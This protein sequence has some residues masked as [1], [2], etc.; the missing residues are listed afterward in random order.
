M[1]RILTVIASLLYTASCATMFNRS[2]DKDIEIQTVSARAKVYV[3]GARVR[4][5]K[6]KSYSVGKEECGAKIVAKIGD[7]E[8]C[9]DQQKIKCSFAASFFLNFL[10]PSL[11]GIIID[12]ATGSTNKLAKHTYNMQC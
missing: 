10:G 8:Q 3:D 12:F 6:I 5:N 7:G 2:F 11:L 1:I 9:E 4:G